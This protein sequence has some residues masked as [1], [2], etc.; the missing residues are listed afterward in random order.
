MLI[1][2]RPW[3][4]LFAYVTL[5]LRTNVVHQALAHWQAH[6]ESKDAVVPPFKNYCMEIFVLE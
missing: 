6:V 5:Q 3:K 1:G 4:V 2:G